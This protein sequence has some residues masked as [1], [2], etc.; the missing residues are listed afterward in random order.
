MGG[1]GK[2]FLAAEAAR[3]CR[4]AG[5]FPDGVIWHEAEDTSPNR[6]MS[7]V[8]EALASTGRPTS[9]IA[10]PTTSKAVESAYRREMRDHSILVVVD[11][12]RGAA[13]LQ[14]LITDSP[15]SAI[16]ITSRDRMPSLRRT[17]T[18]FIDLKTMSEG[19]ALAL[20]SEK[21]L[22]TASD[23]A[24]ALRSVA[25]LCG[26]LPLALSIA[27]AL[28]S[29]RGMWPSV[30]SF[31]TRLEQR[32]LD[33]LSISGNESLDVRA[34]LL[35]SYEQMDAGQAKLFRS[36]SVLGRRSFGASAV[37]M[38]LARDK[39]ETI[40][41]LS[42]LIQR[43]VLER[44][45]FGRYVLHDLLRELAEELFQRDE[46][47]EEAR[48]LR[49]NAQTYWT[50]WQ[51]ALRLGSL[52]ASYARKGY[53][54]QAI[55][56]YEAA[57]K[58][59]REIGDRK[60]EASALGGLAAAYT[61]VGDT[62]RA[63]VYYEDAQKLNRE[64]G[65]RKGEASALGGLAAAHAK[66]GNARKAIVYYEAAQKLNRELGDAWGQAQALGGLSAVYER[67]LNHAEAVRCMQ[68]ALVFNKHVRHT[69]FIRKSLEVLHRLGRKSRDAELVARCEAELSE[70]DAAS[71]P[72]RPQV[73]RPSQ[74]DA[75]AR[76][77]R[78]LDE[79]GG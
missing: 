74:P 21:S 28:L 6:V 51:E 44:S 75:G 66:M 47:A 61:K 49:L 54:Q 31:Q 76:P 20:L 69:T 59:N 26:W 41:A 9:G 16:L 63:I 4:A 72:E 50:T 19:D 62:R 71:S 65:D 17:L 64:L 34:V 2:T 55:E 32:R 79:E 58:L 24:H 48:A 36:L 42:R 52:A 25:G 11:D 1:A 53:A 14:S 40:L 56:Y 22:I 43:S 7:H 45:S 18:S 35:L 5:L 46:P 73:D 70:L 33:C 30:E 38:M 67:M 23:E 77:P 15:G 10:T 78:G 27:G 29:D 3:R 37:S 8:L 57:H 68:E 39:H 12:A 13:Q 60:G